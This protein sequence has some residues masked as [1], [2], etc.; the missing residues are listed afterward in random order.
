M[1]EHIIIN[2]ETY[3]YECLN[4][5]FKSEPPWMTPPPDIAQDARDHFISEHKDCQSIPF[6]AKAYAKDKIDNA[7]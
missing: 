5:G 1:P 7:N 6:G 2:D 4:C 3:L